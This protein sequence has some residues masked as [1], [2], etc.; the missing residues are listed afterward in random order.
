MTTR[1]HLF[2]T[3]FG[4]I[5]IAWTANGVCR[6]QL[7]ERDRE[8]TARRLSRSL[9]AHSIEEAPTGPIADAVSAL[10]RYFAGEAVDLTQI[11]IDVPADD[12]F[13]LAI[14]QAARDLAHGETTT[15]GALAEKAGRKG[16][17]RETGEALG[18]NPVPIIVPCHRIMAA[19]GR[20]GGFS[21]PGGASTKLRLLELERA[22]PTETRPGQ[23]SFAF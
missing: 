11:A 12:P 9:P 16:L 17:A 15:Y 7:P 8:A 1:W 10:Q 3:A 18:K 5:G 2:E 22:R 23:A 4:W 6:V 21:A 14:W 13:R 20:L 19:G